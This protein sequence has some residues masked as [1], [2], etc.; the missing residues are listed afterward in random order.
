[1][2]VCRTKA[3][4]N[5]LLI[6]FIWLKPRKGTATTG[7]APQ[8]QPRFGILFCEKMHLCGPAG[9]PLQQ[10]INHATH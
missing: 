1:V 3:D 8:L 6:Y 9:T 7:I 2:A 5:R 10:Q 4:P